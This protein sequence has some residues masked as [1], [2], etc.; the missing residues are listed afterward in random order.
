MAAGF[1]VSLRTAGSVTLKTCR[2]IRGQMMLGDGM[3]AL[4]AGPF[5]RATVVRGDAVLADIGAT[6]ATDVAEHIR[7][8]RPHGLLP[9]ENCRKTWTSPPLR[10]IQPLPRQARIRCMRSLLQELAIIQFVPSVVRDAHRD[11]ITKLD[12]TTIGKL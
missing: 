1:G 9:V 12:G 5:T 8:V 7:D 10:A 4:S 11:P 6:D 3:G 2:S